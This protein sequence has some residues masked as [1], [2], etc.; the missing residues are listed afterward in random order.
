MTGTDY[1]KK[2]KQSLMADKERLQ[3]I[4][5]KGIELEQALKERALEDTNAT[6]TRSVRHTTTER[7]KMIYNKTPAAVSEPP[8]ASLSSSVPLTL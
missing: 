2:T 8:L 7:D 5:L 3:K 1:P 6:L 4:V